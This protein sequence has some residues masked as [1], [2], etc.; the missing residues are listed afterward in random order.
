MPYPAQVVGNVVSANSFIGTPGDGSASAGIL[1]V[2][3]GWLSPCPDGGA[4][5]YS[6][7]VFIAG[8]I[9]LNNDTGVNS[10]NA[11]GDFSAPLAPTSVLIYQNLIGSDFCY[12]QAYQ[13]GI[14]DYGNTDY[15]YNN[16]IIQGGGYGPAPCGIGIDVTGSTNPQVGGN[17]VPATTTPALAALR[18]SAPGSMKFQ[19]FQ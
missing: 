3:G 15:I 5:P 16:Y 7:L 9:L 12:N 6:S 13:A 8:N 18:P 10:Y 19:P 4:C 17:N 14:S 1:V 2:G 11:Q